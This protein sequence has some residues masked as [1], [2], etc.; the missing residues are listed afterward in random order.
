MSRREYLEAGRIFRDQ[1]SFYALI[2]AAMQRAD[3]NN[4]RKLRAAYPEVWVE[5][6]LRYDVPGGFLPS[7]NVGIDT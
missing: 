1:P 2:M 4:L 6:Q 3:T 5:L 7:D